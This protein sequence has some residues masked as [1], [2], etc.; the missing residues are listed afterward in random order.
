MMPARSIL[1]ILM[2]LATSVVIRADAIDNCSKKVC[3]PK[4][5]SQ[6]FLNHRTKMNKHYSISKT[7]DEIVE[8]RYPSR[9][10]RNSCLSKTDCSGL[11]V[12]EETNYKNY[13][14]NFL[15][16]SLPRAIQNYFEYF[17]PNSILELYIE[18]IIGR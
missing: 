8:T 14:G 15:N 17:L 10:L 6:R 16:Q 18:E 13:Y 9:I 3:R 11:N 12:Y 5:F 1:L 4:I 2:I 7:T